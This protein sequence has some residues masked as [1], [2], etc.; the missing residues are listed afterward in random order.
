MPLIRLQT[1]EPV[2]QE[3]CKELLAALSKIASETIGKP[4]QYVMVAL[5][6]GPVL[7]SGREGPAAFAD[8]RSIGG[9]SGNVNRQLAQKICALL[10]ASLGIASNRVFINFTDIP[11]SHWG[12][13]GSTFG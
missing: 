5:A 2:P 13:N 3:K 11:A 7:M 1:S 6:S 9:L 4:E 8:V 10:D 12:W